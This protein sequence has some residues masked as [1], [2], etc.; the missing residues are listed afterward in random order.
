MSSIGYKNP[1]REA[2]L[3]RAISKLSPVDRYVLQGMTTPE[4]RAQVAKDKKLKQDMLRY[5][6]R[7]GGGLG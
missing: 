5:I 1:N 2:R 6:P 7:A 3:R 4:A